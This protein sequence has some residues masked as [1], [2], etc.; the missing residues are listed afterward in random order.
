VLAQLTS[1][2]ALSTTTKTNLAGLS[3]TL[4]ANT[5]YIFDFWLLTSANAATVGVRF[6]ITFGGT[7]TRMD[8]A[9]EYYNAAATLDT[10]AIANATSS[11]QSFNPT[12]SQG[13]VTRAYRLT[14]R[15]VVGAS[16]GTLQLQHASETATLTTVMLGSWGVCIPI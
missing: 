14:G 3:F 4:T 2:S 13:N 9:L 11:P 10:L 6:D 5:T 8:A 16:G 12:A 1:Q 7:M 15:I